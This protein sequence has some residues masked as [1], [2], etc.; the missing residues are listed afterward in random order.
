MP[1][2]FEVLV[3]GAG[4]QSA[5]LTFHLAERG[6]QVAVLEKPFVGAGA[7]GRFAEGK[8]VKRNYD[9]IRK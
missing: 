3:I 5:N 1:D 9:N 4:V 8:M 7:P 2:T 6:V